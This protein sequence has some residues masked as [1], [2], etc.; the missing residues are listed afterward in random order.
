MRMT[1]RLRSGPW[2]M[3]SPPVFP[4]WQ[5]TGVSAVAPLQATFFYF[6][7][8]VSAHWRTVGTLEFC[9][10]VLARDMPGLRPLGELDPLEGLGRLAGY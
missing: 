6:V 7:V 5:E 2:V 1:R 3:D 9:E 8:L 10:P 4:A